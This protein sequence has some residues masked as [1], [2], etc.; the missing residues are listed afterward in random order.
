MLFFFRLYILRFLTNLLVNVC[1][2]DFRIYF[3]LDSCLKIFAPKKPA[4]Q[5]SS[6]VSE[7]WGHPKLLMFL[8]IHVEVFDK[9]VS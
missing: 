7:I 5:K 9:I 1:F 3:R 4:S 8:K 6:Q 2:G